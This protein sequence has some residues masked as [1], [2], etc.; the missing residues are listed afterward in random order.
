MLRSGVDRIGDGECER[1]LA[2]RTGRELGNP[3]AQAGRILL[4]EREDPVALED[5]CRAALRERVARPLRP[6]VGRG[7]PV[8]VPIQAVVEL[9]RL[10]ALRAVQRIVVRS[11]ETSRP[12]AW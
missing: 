4:E 8:A 3:E 11:S 5:Q 7:R 9:G 10:Q 2:L 12:P 1:A 6:G